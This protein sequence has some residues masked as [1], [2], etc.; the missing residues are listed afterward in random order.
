[1]KD[2]LKILF[3][4]FTWAFASMLIA[5]VLQP[6]LGIFSLLLL[7]VLAVVGVLV[8]DRYIVK[9]FDLE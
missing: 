3:L 1:M 4:L 9:L 6:T 5:L 2:V 8:I 7:V